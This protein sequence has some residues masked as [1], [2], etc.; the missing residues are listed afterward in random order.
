MQLGIPQS[1]SMWDWVHEEL[2]ITRCAQDPTI[3]KCV[4]KD[5]LN[6]LVVY[7]CWHKLWD[8]NVW[9]NPRTITAIAYAIQY[10]IFL[11]LTIIA[12][13]LTLTQIIM[14]QVAKIKKILVSTNSYLLY[15]IEN[16]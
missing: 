5:L 14:I 1:F 12:I 4:W 6:R 9:T 3:T 11:E 16:I 7:T 13:V 10:Q 15:Q 8:K 2:T